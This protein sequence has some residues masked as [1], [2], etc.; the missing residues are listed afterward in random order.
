MNEKN[1]ITVESMPYFIAD[2]SAPE[3]NRYVFAYTIT[4]TNQGEIPAK[5][6]RRHWLITDSNGKIQ[7][8]RGEGVVGEQPYLKPGESFRYTSGLMLETSV[9]TMQG[10]YTMRSD[11]GDDFNANVPVLTLSIPR[12]LH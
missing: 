7:E 3:K 11:D 5:L 12:T 10:S 6:L 9:G 1:N 2:Q 8:V 4:I